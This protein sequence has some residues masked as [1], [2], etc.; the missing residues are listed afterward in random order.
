MLQTAMSLMP[1]VFVGVVLGIGIAIWGS[2]N[3]LSCTFSVLGITHMLIDVSVMDVV[4]L[5]VAILGL[6]FV[7][8]LVSAYRIKQIS[9]Y[10][11]LTE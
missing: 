11:L 4:S 9:V 6:S 7:T 2:P 5:A 1:T 10:E 8:T 3:I